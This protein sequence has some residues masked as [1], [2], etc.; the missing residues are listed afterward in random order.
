VNKKLIGTRAKHPKEQKNPKHNVYPE[1][2]FFLI[3]QILLMQLTISDIEKKNIIV[4]LKPNSGFIFTGLKGIIKIF[5]IQRINIIISKTIKNNS[6]F[7]ELNLLRQP[8]TLENFSILLSFL[9]SCIDKNVKF[10]FN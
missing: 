6:I 5:I 3:L 4:I 9:Y 10:Y 8:T 2:N 7:P 1:F